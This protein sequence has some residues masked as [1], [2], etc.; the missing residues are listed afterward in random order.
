MSQ[1]KY[2]ECRR[3]CRYNYTPEERLEKGRALADEYQ[4]LD[5]VNS[6][7]ERVKKQYK[8]RIETHEATIA[9]LAEQ[10]RS[11]YEMRETPCFFEYNKPRPGR[12]TLKRSDT[13]EVVGEEDMTGQDMQ[14]VMKSVDDEAAATTPPAGPESKR[15]PILVL[16]AAE[17]PFEPWPESQEVALRNCP[18][19]GSVR[20]N[21]ASCELFAGLLRECFYRADDTSCASDDELRKNVADL[22]KRNDATSLC[23]EILDWI[24]ERPRPGGR[25]VAT[26]LREYGIKTPAEVSSDA[27]KKDSP[28]DTPAQKKPRK[29]KGDDIAGKGR[30]TSRGGVVAC[31]SDGDDI[32]D[33]ES[34]KS[35]Y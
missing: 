27:D 31:D 9:N 8:A 16:P 30:R 3:Q 34:N 21:T 10:V 28:P 5:A 17:P 12:K 7:L 18:V 23:S 6:D 1:L 33:P 26:L 22:V 11:G 24:N 14:M 15:D 25:K 29:K 19:F 13:F 20:Y 35:D 4:A 32:D 2:N